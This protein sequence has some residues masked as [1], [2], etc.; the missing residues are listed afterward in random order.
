MH[1]FFAALLNRDPYSRLY[2]QEVRFTF[3]GTYNNLLRAGAVAVTGGRVNMSAA[4][5]CL[6]DGWALA[7]AMRLT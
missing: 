3:H 5:T 4:S 7:Y 6:E 1:E 2:A